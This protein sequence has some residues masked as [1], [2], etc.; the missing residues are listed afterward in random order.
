MTET[1]RETLYQCRVLLPE[2]MFAGVAIA[3][4]DP[5]D[6]DALRTMNLIVDWIAAAEAKKP[7]DEMLCLDCN[8]RFD[9]ITVPAAFL[10]ALPLFEGKVGVVSGICASCL[11]G[12]LDEKLKRRLPMM[13]CNFELKTVGHA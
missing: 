1:N 6:R 9:G 11:Q 3:A 7:G 10:T 13:F 2:Q 4:L 12:N 8:I 5:S